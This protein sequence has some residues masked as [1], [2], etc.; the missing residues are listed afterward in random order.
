MRIWHRSPALLL[1]VCLLFMAPS[2]GGGS[3]KVAVEEVAGRLAATTGRSKP[4]LLAAM[5][6]ANLGASVSEEGQRAVEGALGSQ[7]IADAA[8]PAVKVACAYL[9]KRATYVD[10]RGVPTAADL[11][12]RMRTAQARGE[13]VKI[14][15]VVAE[16]LVSADP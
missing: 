4:D 1:P 14:A 11:V 15:C 5:R 7:I 6:K 10:V 13:Q 16:A 12:E 3:A 8:D 2:C 9:E